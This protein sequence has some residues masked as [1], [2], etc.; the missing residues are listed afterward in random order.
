[1]TSIV[2]PGTKI[3]EDDEVGNLKLDR[4]IFLKRVYECL[5]VRTCSI[6][7]GIPNTPFFQVLRTLFVLSMPNFV[8][9]MKFHIGRFQSKGRWH[10]L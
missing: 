1:M 10:Q 6:H 9:R 5:P 4:I 8:K 3:P 2:W 7:F